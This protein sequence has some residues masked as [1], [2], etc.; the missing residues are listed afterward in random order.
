MFKY[1]CVERYKNAMLKNHV[2][3]KKIPQR[4]DVNDINGALYYD[5]VSKF[6]TNFTHRTKFSSRSWWYFDNTG[7]ARLIRSHSSARIYF[8]LSGNSN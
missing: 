2:N 5:K 4:I 7:R 1:T 3:L 6:G 8:E